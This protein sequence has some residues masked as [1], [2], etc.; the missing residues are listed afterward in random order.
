MKNWTKYI[1]VL[2]LLTILSTV[3]ASAQT[4]P[5]IVRTVNV[6]WV[7]ATTATNGAALISLTNVYWAP[8]T[9]GPWT[10]VNPA[11]LVGTGYADVDVP[12]GST[13]F[14]RVTAI[15]P[16]T[17][18][19]NST[20]TVVALG[21]STPSAAVSVAVPNTLPPPNAPTSVTVTVT[22]TVAP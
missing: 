2:G 13:R 21:E 10:P 9:T 8:A 6:S 4:A 14:Y 22:V 3:S 7:R 17:G 19:V 18:C 12:G 1:A 20:G 11:P 15:C 16:V 5:T